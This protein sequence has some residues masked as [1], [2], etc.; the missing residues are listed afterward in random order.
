MYLY[1]TQELKDKVVT[2]D[3]FKIHLKPIR[4]K[5]KKQNKAW[6]LNSNRK[7]MKLI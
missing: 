6:C 2:L 1:W 4:E 3:I 7:A 5:K